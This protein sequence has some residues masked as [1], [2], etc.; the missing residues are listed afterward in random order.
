MFRAQPKKAAAWVL[1]VGCGGMFAYYALTAVLAFAGVGTVECASFAADGAPQVPAPLIRSA[2]SGPWS[3]LATWEG[4]K[5][6]N[7]GE[8]V[9]IRTG[10]RVVY[11]LS[12]PV[13]DRETRSYFN[14]VLRSIH[15]AGILAFARDRNTRLN[16]GLIKIQAGDDASEDGFKC[17]AHVRAPRSEEHTSELQSP[18]HIVC[19]L[20]L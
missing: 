3:A 2:Q 9:Q 11:D 7:K 12:L 20:P 6:P 14:P 1:A 15:V 10:H 5:L 16:V 13:V 18:D 8:R 4:G 17:D 19:R